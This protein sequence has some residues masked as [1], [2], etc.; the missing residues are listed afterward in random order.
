MTVVQGSDL[1]S[2]QRLT[3]WEMNFL[4]IM[5]YALCSLRIALCENTF[6]L[7]MCHG[8]QL[9]VPYTRTYIDQH[10]HGLIEARA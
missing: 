1:G 4:N 2:Y 10:H 8:M 3:C 9:I 5:S 7:L 6:T